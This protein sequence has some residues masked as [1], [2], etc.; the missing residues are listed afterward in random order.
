MSQRVALDTMARPRNMR[1]SANRTPVA[2]A[3][4]PSPSTMTS[5]TCARFSACLRMAIN[6]EKM[7]TAKQAHAVTACF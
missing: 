3:A 7:N 2:R 5:R 6:T 1:P 4:G